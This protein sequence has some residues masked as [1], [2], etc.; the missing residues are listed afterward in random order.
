[1]SKKNSSRLFSDQ[2]Q[3][4]DPVALAKQP[5]KVGVHPTERE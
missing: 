5:V 1:M 4:T 3:Q 2:A